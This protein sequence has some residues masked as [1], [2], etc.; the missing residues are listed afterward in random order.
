M[1]SK[2][3][4][5]NKKVFLTGHTG[6]KGTWLNLFLNELGAKT[7]GYS[8]KPDTNP[9]FFNIISKSK[10]LNGEFGDIRNYNK[11]NASIK[12]FQPEI[13]I[14]LAAQPL[15]RKSYDYPIDTFNTN[16]IGTMNILEALRNQKKCHSL[17]NVT[18]DKCYLNF[19]SNVPFKE[20]DPLGGLDPYSASKA[21]SEI[22]TQAYYHSYFKQNKSVGIATARAG[23][24]IGGGDW[25]QDRLIPDLVRSFDTKKIVYIR[26]PHATRPWQYVLDA[27]RGYLI[28]SQ[29]L[30]LNPKKFSGSWN[31]GPNSKSVKTVDWI[32]ENFS[33]KMHHSIKWKVKKDKKYYEATYLT[34]N[35]SKATK[36]LNWKPKNSL[37]SSLRSIAN[38]YLSY[39]NDK[40]I[41]EISKKEILSYIN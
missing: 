41:Y 35:S 14:H 11:L 10:K 38:W 25:S 33:Q 24:I 13:I 26:S 19:N 31:F 23:N 17:I 40:D 32:T 21:S 7:Y 6:F 18:T 1:I 29:R 30:Y 2:K 9:S 34:L 28:L 12:K 36:L 27:L 16:F 8:L 4:W 20:E 22:I 3:F 39:F 37:S 15:V 5:N